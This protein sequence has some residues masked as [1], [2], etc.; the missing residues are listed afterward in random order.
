VSPLLCA[1]FFLSP[2]VLA[3]PTAAR[4]EPGT[5][6]SDT[7]SVFDKHEYRIPMRDGVRL[8]TAVYVPKDESL[9]SPFL[10]YRTRYGVRHYGPDVYAPL[11]D[12]AWPD[13][14]G[15]P[16]IFVLQDVR[17][18]FLSE[19][20][21]VDMTPHVVHKRGPEDV[22]QS[23]DTY[24]TIEWLL[25]NVPRNNGRV[26][27]WGISYDGFFTAAGMI[28]AHP[29]LV[30]ASPQAP[31]ADW[32][33]GDD[34]HLHGALVLDGFEYFSAWGRPRRAPTTEPP[35]PIDFGT[36]DG[37]AFYLRAGPVRNLDERYFK[38]EVPIWSA[39]TMHG[40][41][42][43]FWK[44][45]NILPHLVDVRPA[46]MTVS[47]WFDAN[48]LYG[49]LHVY[50]TVEKTSPG[51]INTLVIGPWSH[52]QW[53]RGS[54]ESLGDVR[55]GA[56]T[57]DF[58]RKRIL[59]PFFDSRL[60]EDEKVA[61]R[62]PE[63]YV[64]E[65]GSNRWRT[66]DHWPP[67]SASSRSLYLREDG[68]LSFEP[69]PSEED[70]F[71]EYASDPAKPVPFIERLAT[72]RTSDYMIQDQRFASRRPD[73]LVYETEL[74]S[75]EVTVAG[76]IRPSLWVSTTGT[77]ADWVVKLIDVYPDDAPETAATTGTG[78]LRPGDSM[79]G[80]QQLVRGDVLRGKFRES[81]ERPVP[82]VPGEPTRVEL[83]MLDVFHTFR[84]GHRIMVQ[85]QSTWFPL[86]DRNPQ[87]FVDIYHATDADFRKATHRVYRSAIRSS[88]VQIP[89]LP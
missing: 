67:S 66:F 42:D 86:V 32:F 23:T 17:G 12:I 31:Q 79:A 26:G 62:L 30:A 71:D 49:A 63:A 82:F 10:M 89:V 83:E 46:V 15:P 57:A 85:I 47:G 34:L 3:A 59:R 27:L 61:P 78:P 5:L 65:T 84:K 76:P 87:T 50:Q 81:L 74:L 18:S 14:A 58:Y 45:R 2:V 21:F 25:K 48:N 24:D 77:D 28:D 9:Q 22:D 68:G 60:V 36:P 72:D 54:G 1:V 41:Y 19:G 33:G 37:Y 53:H 29:A 40:T 64:F 51:T 7:R 43:T 4:K 69:S 56:A 55:F 20:T 73:V 52:G 13:F 8:Y 75:A 11:E 6:P 39:V 44:E 80:Y 88:S 38:D 16:Y 35:R 70:L